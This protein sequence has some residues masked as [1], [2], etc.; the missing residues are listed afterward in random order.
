MRIKASGTIKVEHKGKDSGK[1][2]VEF[3]NDIIDLYEWFI[4]KEF[5]FRLHKPKYKAHITVASTKHHKDIDW[6]RA[7][8]YDGER[9]EFEYDPDMSRGGWKKG[10]IMFYLKV[11]SEEL[12]KMKEDVNVVESPSYRGLHITLGNGNKNG[13]KPI[14]YWPEMI[15]IK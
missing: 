13:N 3:D 12:D 5:W 2:V 1:I 15:T 9:V 10:F 6:A 11:F 4:K 7:E 8:Y 14:P